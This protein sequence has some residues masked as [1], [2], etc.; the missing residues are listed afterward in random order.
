MRFKDVDRVEAHLILV[1]VGQLVQ[2]GNLPPKWRS[3]VAP[4]N[5]HDRLLSPE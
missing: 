3:G 1:L 4:E 2:G 5:Q